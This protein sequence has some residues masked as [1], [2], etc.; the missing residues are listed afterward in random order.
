MTTIIKNSAPSVSERTTKL[1]NIGRL[2][3]NKDATGK[4]PPI[5]GQIDRSLGVSVTLSANDKLVFFRNTKREGTRDA[6]FRIA[7]ELPT[8]M[9]DEVIAS[10]MSSRGKTNEDLAIPH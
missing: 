6:D 1:V 4:K 2:W 7:I 8:A 9:A 5:S 3:I 10:Q